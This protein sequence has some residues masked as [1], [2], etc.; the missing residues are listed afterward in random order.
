MFG[1]L[2]GNFLSSLREFLYEQCSLHITEKIPSSVKLGSRPRIFL[3]RSNSSWA[4]PCCLMSSGVTAG[5]AVGIWLIIGRFTLANLQVR[6]ITQIRIFIKSRHLRSVRQ[7][8]ELRTLGV[9]MREGL[10]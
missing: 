3:I 2:V 1:P 10:W 5:S 8:L 4:R 7:L 9:K 6:S